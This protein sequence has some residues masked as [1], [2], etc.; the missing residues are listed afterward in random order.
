MVLKRLQDYLRHLRKRSNWCHE[1]IAKYCQT[2]CQLSLIQ[3]QSST[4]YMSPSLNLFQ[5]QLWVK[6]S[7]L[8]NTLCTEQRSV[9]MQELQHCKWLQLHTQNSA[10]QFD[11]SFT[12]QNNIRHTVHEAAVWTLAPPQHITWLKHVG[13]FSCHTQEVKTTCA[14]SATCHAKWSFSG[15]FS[16]LSYGLQSYL[17]ASW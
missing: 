4:S 1:I 9:G 3:T 13:H 5:C 12:H 17:N 11:V 15:S 7:K 16:L 14:F 8:C 2:A 10:Q 6:R